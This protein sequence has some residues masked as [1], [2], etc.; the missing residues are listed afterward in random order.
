[1]HRT[2]RRGFAVRASG[3]AWPQQG[4]LTKRTGRSGR[5][6]WFESGVRAFCNPLCVRVWWAQDAWGAHLTAS[7]GQQVTVRDRRVGV[8]RT[9]CGRHQ[10]IRRR[11]RAS[12]GSLLSIWCSRIQPNYRANGSIC[13]GGL[14]I[15]GGQLW[16]VLSCTLAYLRHTLS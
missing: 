12:G 8:N 7:G 1:M 10:G 2:R 13:W 4:F 14:W 11:V 15:E 16:G 3:V 6:Q 9:T 5:V